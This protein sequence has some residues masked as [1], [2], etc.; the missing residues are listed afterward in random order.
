MPR[1]P[2]PN[3][4]LVAAPGR[5]V[6]ELPDEAGLL[7]DEEAAEVVAGLE[8]DV[9]AGVAGTEAGVVAGGV[10]GLT[11]GGVATAEVTAGKKWTKICKLSIFYQENK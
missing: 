2:Y 4:I 10:V 9:T 7:A 6:L 11:G 3:S 5:P 8:D 1:P